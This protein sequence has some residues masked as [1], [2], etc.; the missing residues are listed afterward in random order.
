M[1]WSSLIQHLSAHGFAR[2]GCRGFVY[3]RMQT[4]STIGAACFCAACIFLVFNLCFRHLQKKHLETVSKI[5]PA[6][7]IVTLIITTLIF[8]ANVVLI[9]QCLEQ[10]CWGI[11]HRI[12]FY[13]VI[14]PKAISEK[15]GTFDSKYRTLHLD[16]VNYANFSVFCVYVPSSCTSLFVLT[17]VSACDHVIHVVTIRSLMYLS[18][19]LDGDY[20]C[21][22]MKE[23]LKVA[24][25][26]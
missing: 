18:W 1:L 19:G 20:R 17:A 24:D 26:L 9:P 23:G 25:E 16:S 7:A 6:A 3:T 11:P 13:P 21:G 22:P 8:S 12:I 15:T 5:R 2:L 4:I 10:G 14:P